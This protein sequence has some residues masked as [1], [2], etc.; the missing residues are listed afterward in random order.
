MK[1]F[2]I[3]EQ[4]KRQVLTNRKFLYD[5]YLP[6]QDRLSCLRNPRLYFLHRNLNR[7]LIAQRTGWENFYCDNYFYQGYARIGI[8]GVKPSEE[9][10]NNYDIHNYFETKRKVLDIGSNCGFF[11]LHVSQYVQE[12][13]GIEINP[14]LN[15]IAEDTQKYLNIRNARFST[16]DFTRVTVSEMYDVVF[17]LSNHHTIDGNL[18]M[19]FENYIRKIFS[20]LKVDGL[21]FFESHN[22][23]GDGKLG[24]GDDSNLDDKFDIAEQYFE[25]LKCKMVRCFYPG[26]DID[27]LFV[28]M[29]RRPE[30]DSTIKRRLHLEQTK[31][32]YEYLTF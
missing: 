11:A 6:M 30:P 10:F 8:A 1:I 27:K 23:W 16:A 4:K 24:P 19:G 9:R 32:S 2:E 18:N 21:L 7:Y 5:F 20:C 26:V 29:K 28:V 22:V 25:V 17:S 31:K 14:Y 15:S 13:H 12:I 3:L